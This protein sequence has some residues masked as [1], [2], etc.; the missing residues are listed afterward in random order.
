MELGASECDA[1]VSVTSQQR[2]IA[3]T[4]AAME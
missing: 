4:Q 3:I 1:D 2:S